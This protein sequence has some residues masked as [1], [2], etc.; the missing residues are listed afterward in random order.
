MPSRVAQAASP[1]LFGLLIDA[2]GT[3]VLWF[4]SVLYAAG[5]AGL[6]TLRQRR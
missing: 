5:L 1:L 2:L 4:T 3:G 6:L